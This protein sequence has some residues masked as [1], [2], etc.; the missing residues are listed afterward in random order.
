MLEEPSTP[1]ERLGCVSTWE[2]AG[3]MSLGLNPGCDILDSEAEEG[4]GK[5]DL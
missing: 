1:C 5:D 2:G 3:A 4:G